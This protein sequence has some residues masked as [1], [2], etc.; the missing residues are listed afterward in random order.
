LLVQDFSSFFTRAL[1]AMN[2]LLSAAF[3][4]SHKCGYYVSIFSLNYRKSLITYFISSLSKLSLNRELFRFYVY[5]G[6]LLFLLLFK[7]SL[8]PW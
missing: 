6:F 1:S 7:T 3:I 2:F 4:V 8:R 5:M